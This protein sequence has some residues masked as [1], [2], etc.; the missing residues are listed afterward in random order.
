M[1][2]GY[3]NYLRGKIRVKEWAE[4]PNK[5]IKTSEPGR[6]KAGTH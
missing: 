4:K 5:R 2:A 1:N 3:V 6:T